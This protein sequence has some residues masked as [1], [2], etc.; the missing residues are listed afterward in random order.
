MRNKVICLFLAALF[1][2]LVQPVFLEA[3]EIIAIKSAEI[4]PYN[5]ALEGFRTSCEHDV[6]E[7]VMTD[8]E[9]ADILRKVHESNTVAVLAIGMDALNLARSVRDIPVIY[10]MVP[11]S[12]TQGPEARPL[13]GVS[14]Y[15][16]PD[17][18]IGS[19]LDVF[20]GTKRIGVIYDP[21]NSEAY[22]RE[23]LQSA[24]TRGVD[25]LFRKASRPADIPAL[26]DSMKDKID[27]FWMLPD[28]TVINPET[29]KYLLLFSFQNK[30]PVFTFSRKYVEIG[31]AAGLYTVPFDIGVQAGE[32]AR[33]IVAENK[34]KTVRTD[35]RKT[36]LA[37]NRKIMRKLGIKVRDEVLK[38]AENVD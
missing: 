4:K 19:M 2:Q 3:G 15:I 14:M 17:R 10:A 24:Q 34:P 31:S 7:V 8:T 1:L 35:A 37:V 23:A 20:Q 33:K 36:V 27:V 21:R 30:V 38:R 18:Y 11:H 16:P 22:M 12:P 32:I 9:S 28:T 29:V 26:I 13:S 25:L 5:D 6:T